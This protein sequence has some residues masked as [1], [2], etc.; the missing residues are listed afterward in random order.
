MKDRS[1]ELA[2]VIVAYRASRDLVDALD[3]VAAA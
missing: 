2:S 1:D 3:A